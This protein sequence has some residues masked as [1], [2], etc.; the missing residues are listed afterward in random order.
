MKIN[1]LPLRPERGVRTF[2][3][4]KELTAFETAKPVPQA[5]LKGHLKFQQASYRL[6]GKSNIIPTSHICKNG[7][8]VITNQ[9][10][11][12]THLLPTVNSPELRGQTRNR[13][14][15]RENSHTSKK[16]SIRSHSSASGER[17]GFWT[18]TDATCCLRELSI[19][20]HCRQHLCTT[21][22]FSA[23]FVNLHTKLKIHVGGNAVAVTGML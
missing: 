20:A 11:K 4:K 5:V 9:G 10:R 23:K 17:K 13:G 8:M 6:K 7:I 2:S 19:E 21:L 1:Y 16:G 18:M 3:D 12:F 22:R 14:E 15:R